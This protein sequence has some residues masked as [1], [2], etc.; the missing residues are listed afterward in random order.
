MLHFAQHDSDSG[1]VL[2]RPS[3]ET[4]LWIVV[5]ASAVLVRLASLTN[6]PFSAAEAQRAYAAWQFADGQSS[7][8]DGGLW[9][10]FP[11][12]INGLFFFLF[13]ARDG[14]AR[15]GPALAGI[16]IVPVCWWLRPH[17]GRW[18]ALGTAAMLALS[19]TFVYGSRQVTGMPWV[20]LAALGLFI[21]LLRLAEE[22]APAAT[23]V[24]GGIAVAVL[25]GSGPT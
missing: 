21:C 19:P 14:I 1:F 10:P 15:L 20:A 2:P 13:G 11:F 7:R 3:L 18:G 16:A 12:L 24:V 9:G 23:L 17:L 25:I 8:V 5:I 22:R 6:N 4:I